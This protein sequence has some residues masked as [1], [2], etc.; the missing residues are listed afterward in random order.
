MK[1]QRIDYQNGYL[2]VDKKAKI[3]VGDTYVLIATDGIDDPTYLVRVL[4]SNYKPFGYKVIVQSPNLSIPNVPYVEFEEDVDAALEK[5][6]NCKK[7]LFQAKEW[8]WMKRAYKAAQSK[9]RYSEDDLKTKMKKWCMNPDMHLW[10][11][12]FI[13]SLNQPPLEIEIEMEK[14]F[15]P[16]NGEPSTVQS[17][18]GEPFNYKPVT[19]M[20]DGKT[21]LKV[22]S[23]SE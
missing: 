3:K 14:I 2:W 22:K 5:E 12:D 21:Y 15:Y 8:G 1:L 18:W 19:Y 23:C 13:K 10:V 20:R 4:E 16:K 11:I 7:D 9:G 17:G 6:F